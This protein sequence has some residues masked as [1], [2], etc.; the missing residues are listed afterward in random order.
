[1]STPVPWSCC[2]PGSSEPACSVS[3]KKHPSALKLETMHKIGLSLYLALLVPILIGCA[4][5]P[6]GG[7]RAG[8]EPQAVEIDQI[9]PV[10]SGGNQQAVLSLHK[11]YLAA[12]TCTFGLTLT[13]RLEDKI[14][15]IAFRFAAY[16]KGD[17]FYQDVMRNFFEIDPGDGQYR[18]IGFPK[19]SCDEVSYLEITDPG[20]CTLGELKRLSSQPG[21][22]IRHVYIAETPY[23]KLV[24][25]CQ[26][27]AADSAED[28]LRD[29]IRDLTRN[30]YHC[31]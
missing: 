27:T 12:D 21:D 2:G 15:N 4:K 6:S 13:N 29:V 22:C 1:M 30:D 31:S 26:G 16:V 8:E 17:V 7:D 19:I 28:T 25:K 20:R 5:T 10:T 14:T 23:V 18:E 24:R 11:K 3:L 9:D